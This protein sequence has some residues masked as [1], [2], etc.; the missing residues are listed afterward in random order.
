MTRPVVVFLSCATAIIAASQC[1]P[2]GTASLSTTGPTSANRDGTPI[3]LRL[4]ATDPNGKVGAGQ[5][6]V[7]T[8][9]GDLGESSLTLDEFGTAATTFSCNLATTPDC[10]VDAAKLR[11][12][13]NTTPPVT[14]DF[15]IRLRNAAGNDGGSGVDAGEYCRAASYS[16]SPC[17]G[18]QSPGVGITCCRDNTMIPSCL[19]A[20][21]CNGAKVTRHFAIRGAGQTG[22]VTW[23][24]EFR[25][26]QTRPATF[27]ECK[28][29]E[30]GVIIREN[31]TVLQGKLRTAANGWVD[32]QDNFW[33]L[34]T[35]DEPAIRTHT[36]LECNT[37]MDGGMGL[38][39][40]LIDR[41][42]EPTGTVSYVP[43]D[44]EQDSFFM[45]GVR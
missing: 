20:F 9:V 6:T 36:D 37:I 24:L 7:T 13:W 5:I 18:L 44:G 30:L 22:E 14:I 45:T 11:A 21:P 8:D 31:G 26:P 1:G 10:A 34:Q 38:W 27:A 41:Y 35:G 4:V 15:T 39:H 29:Q 23:E 43:L 19:D 2:T 3:T 25:V 28:Q 42:H 16:K 32:S 17:S 12:T 33:A 40:K